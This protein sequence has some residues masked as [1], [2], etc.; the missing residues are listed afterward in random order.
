MKRALSYLVIGPVLFG[1]FSNAQVTPPAAEVYQPE[2]EAELRARMVDFQPYCSTKRC[3]ARWEVY[4]HAKKEELYVAKQI[5]A[6]SHNL[7]TRLWSECYD[8][9]TS[10]QHRTVG[11]CSKDPAVVAQHKKTLEA[12]G[13]V[14]ALEAD[15]RAFN[16]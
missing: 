3:K 2:T 10:K 4:P 9:L 5:A 11:L 12:L 1:L 16:K 15:L 6:N 13:K 7:E 8:K 14:G